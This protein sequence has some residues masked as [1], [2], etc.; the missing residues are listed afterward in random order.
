MG[1]DINGSV[2][3]LLDANAN[4]ARE[5]LR[6]IEDYAR[7]IVNSASLQ[8]ELKQLRHDLSE[9]TESLLS[10][11]M[12]HRDTPGDVGTAN[13][14]EHEFDRE[15]LTDVV[16]AAG[17]RAGEALRAIEEY[18]K[19]LS[20]YDA[21]KVESVRYRFYEIERK[22]AFTLRRAESD[23]SDVRLCVLITE[24]SCKIPWLKA[25]EQAALGGANCLQLREKTLEAAELLRRA[26]QLVDLCRRY[27]I[28]S[29]IN[30]RLDIALLSGADGVHVGQGDLPAR[31]I[32]RLVGSERIVGVSTH[33]IEQARQAVLDGADYIGVGPIFPSATKPQSLV[34]G[35]VYARQVAAEIAVP[36]VAISGITSGNLAEV[37][38]TGMRSIAVTDAV[39]AAPDIKAAAAALKELLRA[40]SPLVAAA[41]PPAP[42]RAARA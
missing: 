19:V 42:P 25:A 5:A 22:I 23:F 12:L 26:K 2:L 4:R 9:A 18:L 35:T 21:A 3:R 7:F 11:A 37:L 36:T 41:R 28:K 39:L 32:R 29:I 27:G 1:A 40:R 14:T 6:V 34:A 30:D 8:A 31:E 17:K 38:A 10:E 15:D 20:P 33:K 24:A 16:T 13:S